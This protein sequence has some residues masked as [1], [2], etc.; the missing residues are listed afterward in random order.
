MHHT[1]IYT[2]ANIRESLRKY[3]T[4][5]TRMQMYAGNV[6]IGYGQVSELTQ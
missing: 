2:R 5:N 1:S 3:L 6:R 4:H